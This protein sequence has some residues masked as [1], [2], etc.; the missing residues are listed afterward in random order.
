MRN[1]RYAS[2]T[3]GP[4]AC[5]PLVSAG[6]R[7]RT[8]GEEVPAGGCVPV[9]EEEVVR[10]RPD[11][12]PGAPTSHTDG[13]FGGDVAVPGGV[14]CH[15]PDLPQHVSSPW[16]GE[17]DG[18]VPAVEGQ[19]AGRPLLAV[20]WLPADRPNVWYGQVAVLIHYVKSA[21]GCSESP[22]PTVTGVGDPDCEARG[23]GGHV[24]PLLGGIELPLE[25]VKHW[26]HQEG[27]EERALN[28]TL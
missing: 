2:Q 13:D 14:Y 10:V 9:A 23:Q 15:V 8:E 6:Q 7:P 4:R 28:A 22:S 1:P 25:D 17:R 20:I 19:Q 27:E 3:P 26:V 16:S 11:E 18:Q 5:R 21:G 24:P 12:S